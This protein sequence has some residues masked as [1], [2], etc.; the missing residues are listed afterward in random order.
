MFGL[1]FVSDGQNEGLI[2]MALTPAAQLA[3]LLCGTVTHVHSYEIA[4]LPA[5][6]EDNAV[7]KVCVT[8]NEWHD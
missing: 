8:S 3:L 5:E 2:I 1:V 7:K 4:M 6:L